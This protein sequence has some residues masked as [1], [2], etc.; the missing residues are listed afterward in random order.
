MFPTAV[1]VTA[2]SMNAS[3]RSPNISIMMK[4]AV[5]CKVVP[6]MPMDSKFLSIP[7]ENLN[8]VAIAVQKRN[9]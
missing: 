2:W 5:P 7:D 8:C 1:P 3:V 4:K 6:T 9:D